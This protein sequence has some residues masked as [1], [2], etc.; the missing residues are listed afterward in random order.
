MDN[1]IIAF[2]F[3]L[4]FSLILY[5]AYRNASVYSKLRSLDNRLKK[6]EEGFEKSLE[7]IDN[8]IIKQG[9]E[10]LEDDIRDSKGIKRKRFY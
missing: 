8:E 1:G 4:A 3:I 6:L 10:N 2:Y 9:I 5:L 7:D